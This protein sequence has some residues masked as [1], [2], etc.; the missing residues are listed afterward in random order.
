MNMIRKCARKGALLAASAA[1]LA[2][3]AT[4]QEASA[5]DTALTGVATGL[6]GVATSAASKAPAIIASGLI[7]TGITIGVTWLI[8]TFFR[9]KK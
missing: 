9:A 1:A 4:A 7:L 8:R 5:L 3:P 6:D 2:I